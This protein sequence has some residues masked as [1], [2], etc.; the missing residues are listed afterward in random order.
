M[1]ARKAVNAGAGSMDRGSKAGAGGWGR[2][3]C[4][5]GGAVGSVGRATN[6]DMG[7][8][9][10]DT[11]GRPGRLSSTIVSLVVIMCC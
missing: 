2:E 4:R 1:D 6:L 11:L 7:C 5:I 9:W 3:A 8:V 10:G